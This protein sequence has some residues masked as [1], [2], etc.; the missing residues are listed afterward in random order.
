MFLSLLVACS[1]FG[2]NKAAAGDPGVGTEDSAAPVDT[3]T[4]TTPVDTD[5]TGTGTDTV[6]E[7][8]DCTGVDF[9]AWSWWGSQPIAEEAD[10]EDAAGHAF[11]DPAYD[12]V[13]WSTVV[14][15]EHN[16]PV[17]ADRAYLAHFSLPTVPEN[18]SFDLASDDGLWLWLNGT[19]VG[20]W[21]GEW[22]EEGCV[23]DDA[24]CVITVSVA[25]VDV[26][27][28]VLPGDNVIAAR[29]S[30]P[31]MDAWFD[32]QARCVE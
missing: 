31:V 11:W 21:G 17:G 18:V 23:N 27:A 32:V 14:L 10:P 28:S 19:F 12:M 7:E 1:D 6:T 3:G 20:H 16:I 25:A 30:N 9:G 26:T 5:P 24:G 13:G 2:L 29:V 4:E 8:V 22:Q 15:P